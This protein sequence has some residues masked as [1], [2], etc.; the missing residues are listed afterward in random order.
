LGKKPEIDNRK[1]DSIFNKCCWSNRL[2]LYRRVQ[3]DPS[4]SPCTKLK[5]KWIKDL[6]IKPDT[7]NLIECI[8]TGDNVL[9][10]RPIAQA[11]R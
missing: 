11:L 10:R 2:L 5:S 3:I 4:L 6:N 9:N 8:G 1:K 7:L